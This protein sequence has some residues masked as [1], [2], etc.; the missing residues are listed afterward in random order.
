MDQSIKIRPASLDDLQ[1]LLELEALFPGDRLSKR[2]F[3]YLL[4]KGNA[5]IHVCDSGGTM[6]GNAVVLY[7]RNSG[8]ARIYSLVAH[9]S[10]RRQGIA[11]ALLERAE[12]A[13][14]ARGCSAIALEVRAD[15]M[16]AQHLYRSLGFILKRR[17]DGYYEDQAPAVRLEKELSGDQS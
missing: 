16:E 11:K 6:A 10:R 8:Q 7:R 17:I 3:R 4:L 2:S 13:A 9:P 15:N 14:L 1:G 12:Q 5:D